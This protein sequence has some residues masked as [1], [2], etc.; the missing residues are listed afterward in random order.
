MTSA[1]GFYFGVGL[2][3]A[4]LVRDRPGVLPNGLNVDEREGDLDIGVPLPGPGREIIR[5]MCNQNLYPSAQ[6]VEPGKQNSPYRGEVPC[7]P[8]N[9]TKWHCDHRHATAGEAID[10]AR[11]HMGQ[12]SRPLTRL[13]RS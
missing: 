11:Q 9:E 6:W 8:H 7:G 2:S 10:C 1:P 12:M 4:D 13:W 5:S 3:S